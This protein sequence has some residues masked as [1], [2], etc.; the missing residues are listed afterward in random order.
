MEIGAYLCFSGIVWILGLAFVT[1]ARK[2]IG[3][4]AVLSLLFALGALILFYVFSAWAGLVHTERLTS[5]NIPGDY[6]A[7]GAIGIVIMLVGII[8]LFSPT[9]AA[10]IV[11]RQ[12]V[13]KVEGTV[14]K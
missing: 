3:I 13:R 12:S 8:G 6:V 10:W 7:Q 11:S 14:N 4:Y 2:R 9:I 1:R 5:S